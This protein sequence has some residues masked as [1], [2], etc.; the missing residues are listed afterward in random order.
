M[1]KAL[2]MVLAIAIAA[3]LAVSATANEPIVAAG[4]TG[5]LAGT[6][7]RPAPGQPV[8]LIIPG[9]GPTD[10]DGNN[11]M[12]VTAASYR[13]LAEALGARGIGS[14]RIDKRGLF[15]SAAAGVDPNAVTIAA[16]AQ[17]VAAWVTAAR[18]ATGAKCVWLLGHSE[19]GLIALAAAQRA[20]GLCGAILVAAPGRKLGAVMRE[21]LEANP[22]NAPLLGDALPAIAKLEAG[23]RVDVSAMSPVLQGLFAP[24]VQGFLIDLFSHEPAIL[25]AKV[26]VPL[27]IVQGGADLQVPTADGEALRAAQPRASYIVLTG[28]NH[29][30]KAVPTGDRAANLAAYADPSR[31][32]DPSLVTAISG[33]IALSETGLRL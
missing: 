21:Q 19:G 7:I 1:R 2:I 12:G 24:P 29:V 6:M 23:E 31:P 25:A 15:G 17:D 14:V 4:P 8:V 22:A 10:R 20:E 33:F 28:M 13:L 5:Q 16:Y 26:R 32:L 27:L 30:L 3:G 11:P 9:S 18:S